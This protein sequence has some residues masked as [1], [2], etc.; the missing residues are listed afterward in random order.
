[1]GGLPVSTKML[2]VRY[3]GK[4]IQQD[5]C[6]RTESLQTDLYTLD[7]GFNE[8]TGTAEHENIPSKNGARVAR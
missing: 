2:M 4:D 7:M 3:W 5:L 1:M 6:N 8:K